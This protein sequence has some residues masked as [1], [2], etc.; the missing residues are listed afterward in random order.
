MAGDETTQ[1]GTRGQWIRLV[2]VYLL[3]T[4]TLLVCGGDIGW[5]QA[6]L[7]AA[8]IFGAGIGGLI[9]AQRRHPGYAGNILGVFESLLYTQVTNLNLQQVTACDYFRH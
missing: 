7:Y 8:L 1:A 9:W 2:V 4:L 3:I 6:W 5:W